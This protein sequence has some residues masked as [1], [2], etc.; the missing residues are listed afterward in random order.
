MSETRTILEVWA[1]ARRAVYTALSCLGPRE[2]GPVAT[3]IVDT[4]RDGGFL[5][6]AVE[7]HYSGLVVSELL[8]RSDE[9]VNVRCKN[10]VLSPVS[11]DGRGWLIP[12]STL[13]RYLD[14]R[15]FTP[16]E[17][18]NRINPIKTGAKGE[19]IIIKG[20]VDVSPVDAIYGSIDYAASVLGMSDSAA[21]CS[22]DGVAT[23]SATQVVD[24][25]DSANRDVADDADHPQTDRVTTPKQDTLAGKHEA[26]KNGVGGGLGQNQIAT[27]DMGQMNHRIDG[28]ALTIHDSKTAAHHKGGAQ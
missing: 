18:S 27:D 10:G 6:V 2:R 28:K 22:V 8:G 24:N 26:G 25:E 9:Y 13:Q 20:A 7:Y 11:R 14:A 3:R 23:E 1:E 15:I 4:L 16:S 12:A 5:A 17:K 19:K 21:G